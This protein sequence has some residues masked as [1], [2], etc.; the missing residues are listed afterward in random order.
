MHP[1]NGSGLQD[2]LIREFLLGP[3]GLG[4]G[5]VDGFFFDDAWSNHTTGSNACDGS[6]VGGPS[7]ISSFCA[8]DM[9]LS[10]SDTI[11]LTA[12]YAATIEAATN[13]VTAH[14]GFTWN[15]LV[16]FSTPSPGAQCAVQFRDACINSATY[17]DLPI[18]HSYTES[19]GR[20][21]DP[22][23]SFLQDLSAFLL[24]R[25]DYAWLGY[26]WNGCSFHAFPAGISCLP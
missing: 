7:E 15:Q 5:V 10:Q 8:V 24:L 19:P 13:N 23:P 25:G 1:R 16:P 12:S 20:V 22:L 26:S 21:F 18:I 11:A 4:S 17:R 3:T 6:P 9:N 14:G 2:Y